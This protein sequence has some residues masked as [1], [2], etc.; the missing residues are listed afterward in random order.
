MLSHTMCNSA[1]KAYIGG[2]A[3][4]EKPEVLGSIPGRAPFSFSV[5]YLPTAKQ[6]KSNIYLYISRRVCLFS[7]SLES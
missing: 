5:N 4:W 3:S 2:H 7:A 6:L 1:H